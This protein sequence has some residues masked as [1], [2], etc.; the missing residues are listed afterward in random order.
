MASEVADAVEAARIP[1]DENVACSYRLHLTDGNFFSSGTGYPGY[2][3]KTE[4]LAENHDHVLIT[5]ITDYYNQ[6]YLH[7]LGNAIEFADP[8]L[9]PKGDD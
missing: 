5:D 4:E 2:V 7:R 3:Q 6:I 9:K 8:K 1:A